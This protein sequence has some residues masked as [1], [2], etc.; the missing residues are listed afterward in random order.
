MSKHIASYAKAYGVKIN[1]I[2][3]PKVRPGYACWV[4]LWKG[5]NDELMLAFTEKRRASNS[6]YRPIPLE[7]WESMG[8][9][10][11][12]QVS[13]CNGSP[14]VTTESV[15]MRSVDEGKTWIETGRCDSGGLMNCFAYTSLPDGTILRGS[16]TNYLSFYPEEV[17]KGEIQKSDDGGKTWSVSSIFQEKDFSASPY[18][19]KRLGD[20]T[21]IAL[22]GFGNTFGPGRPSRTRLTKEPNVIEASQ[23]GLWISDDNGINWQGPLVVFPGISTDESD[24]VEL[25]SGDLLLLNSKVQGGPEVRQYVHRTKHGFIPGPVYR[26][27]SGIVPETV[28]ITRSGL[29]VG[30]VRSGPYTCSNDEGATWH[31]ISG[32]PKCE[33]QPYIIELK[34]GRFLC[35]WHMFGDCIFGQ[36]HQFVGQHVFR[37]KDNLPAATKLDLT[38]DLNKKKTRY[39]NRYTAHFS[40]GDRGLAKKKIKFWI[41]ERYRDSSAF[42]KDWTKQ[43]KPQ[44]LYRITN[45]NGDAHIHLTGLNKEI[46]IHQGYEIKAYFV[47]S[48]GERIAH[49]ES[50]SYYAYAVTPEKGVENNYPLYVAGEKVFIWPDVLK[51]FSEIK[52]IVEKF[53]N[54]KR[55]K[56]ERLKKMLDLPETRID[57]VMKY[58]SSQNLIKILSPST[59]EWRYKIDRGVEEIEVKDDFV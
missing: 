58:L 9:P 12:Y 24:F 35:A 25:P 57:N 3:H 6:S 11:K 17:A 31:E 7:F 18:R 56:R 10:I 5:A 45:K 41:Q 14:D 44:E 2:Y 8:V 55:F 49:A 43:P 20:G 28:C 59:Y 30:A 48:K 26:V 27:V 15:I 23:N 37:L 38:R 40:S 32:M 42:S 1:D 52:D 50:P 21:L 33:Y 53:G 36:H 39:V 4:S 54:Q 13:F 34:D 19:L 46:N 47:P 51:R 29:L 22:C 16:N